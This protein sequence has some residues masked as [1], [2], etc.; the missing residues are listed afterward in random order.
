MLLRY[1][2]AMRVRNIKMFGQFFPRKL[3]AR[4]LIRKIFFFESGVAAD[5]PVVN[6]KYTLSACFFRSLLLTICV[7]NVYF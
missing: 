2:L 3:R 6:G 5:V 7:I 1:R 4:R